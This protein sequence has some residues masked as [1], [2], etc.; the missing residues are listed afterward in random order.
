[1]SACG[2]LGQS[3]ARCPH[4]TAL[5]A[6][7]NALPDAA[8][9]ALLD[10]L[11]ERT[12]GLAELELGH[13]QLHAA[14]AAAAA[15]L[16]QMGLASLSLCDNRLRVE[17]LAP[18][19]D[20][21]GHNGS[22]R[23]LDLSGNLL[24]QPD[25]RTNARVRAADAAAADAAADA[26]AADADAAAATPTKGGRAPKSRSPV[27]ASSAAPPTK[28][29]AVTAEPV[30]AAAPPP[31]SGLADLALGLR[32]CRGLRSLSLAR[33]GIGAMPPAPAGVVSF[34]VEAAAGE[35]E[36]AVVDADEEAKV[37]AAAAAVA[38]GASKPGHVAAEGSAG[39]ILH[40]VGRATL[41]ALGTLPGRSWRDLAAMPEVSVDP[42]P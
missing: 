26:A 4:L 41:D 31:P 11:A 10:G 27:G 29:G 25:E 7:H 33:N 18:L 9:G 35:K 37:V 20:A 28:G 23:H 21:L 39:Q 16:I 38:G 30:A 42:A 8:G 40:A 19:A 5:H 22:L 6:S 14:A 1:M 36:V 12:G 3:L 2:R 13:N 24:G 34:S 17:D 15:P 32:S